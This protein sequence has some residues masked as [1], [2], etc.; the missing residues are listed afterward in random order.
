MKGR[1]IGQRASATV[2]KERQ[3]RPR[4][5]RWIAPFAL[6]AAL[7]TASVSNAAPSGGTTPADYQQDVQ[8]AGQLMREEDEADR[9]WWAEGRPNPQAHGQAEQARGR[10]MQRLQQKWNAAGMG[11]Q[12]Y[13]DWN[14]AY[15]SGGFASRPPTGGSGGARSTP[16]V[17][18][19]AVADYQQDVTRAADLIREMDAEKRRWFWQKKWQP[20]ESSATPDAGGVELR[21]LN[22]KWTAEGRGAQFYSDYLRQARPPQASLPERF[23][24]VIGGVILLLG[25]LGFLYV[26]SRLFRGRSPVKR[27]L[28]TIYGSA[29]YTP[30]E[31]DVGD[32]AC[33]A[34]GLFLG[35]SSHPDQTRVALNGP[36]APVCSTPEHHTLIVARTRTGKGTRVIVPTLLRYKGSALVIDPKGEN[37]AITGRARRDQLQQ[38]VHIL[39]P[40]NVLPRAYA[41][42]GFTAAT[43][44]PLDIL[45]RNDPNA[46]AIAQT[47]AG[48]ICPTAANPKDKFWQG[49]AADLLTG[50]LLWLADQPTETKTLARAREVVSL[51]RKELKNDFLI[52]MAGSKAFGGAI[53]EF[54]ATFIDM[55][56]E[57]YSGIIA[58]LKQST[59]FLSDPQIKAATA[60]SSFT[61]EDLATAKTTVYVV[62]PTDR[63]DTQKTWLRL[64]IAAA[65]H[66][67]KSLGTTPKL[68]HRC[69]FLI[70]EFAALG[71]LDDLPRDIATMS[72]F[73]VD[74]ALIV[75]G[76]DQLK[77]HYSEA[78]GTILSNCAYKW[79]CNVN[80]LDSAKWLS[81]TLGKTTV[82][83]TS[84]SDSFSTSA[85]NKASQGQSTTRGET[86]RLLLT[87][88]EV[89]NLGKG[90]AIAL[91]P[92]GHPHYLKPVDYWKLTEAFSGLREKHRSLYWQPPLAFDE[93]PY[94][95]KQEEQKK[96]GPSSRRNGK[97]TR[98]EAL[99]IL[100]LKGNPSGAEIEKAYK[101]LMLKVHPDLG[102]S[103]WFARELNQAKEVLLGK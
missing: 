65:M 18:A 51:S 63:M 86:S 55:A 90:V 70:D 54:A 93:N 76:L 39:N 101:R 2:M 21:R 29:H 34:R 69:L 31:T 83:T 44:N 26:L 43:Y 8:R 15:R 85:G 10:E 9:R 102:G 53:R 72:G 91:Q 20:A 4:H 14:Q 87:P 22:E 95:A 73:G 38:N 35:K 32:E 19:A 59:N 36:G 100:E 103:N 66:I 97:M 13:N 46:V 78:K 16:P 5:V 99:E 33:L 79:F 67:F 24:P 84:T 80:D 62:I 68:G 1:P 94:F 81:D 37:A 12:F 60:K 23:A 82:E 58:N 74:F 92:D 45:D 47:L 30:L 27:I 17:D 89:L 57:T 75:Q 28:S 40:W 41:A 71:R 48:A 11:T 52:P 49:S 56:D 7:T 42:R 77:D 61:M 3:H 64:I 25:F 96:E 6:I 88:D 98:K 50:V